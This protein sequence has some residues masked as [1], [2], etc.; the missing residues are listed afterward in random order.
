MVAL[1]LGVAAGSHEHEPESGGPQPGAGSPQD[2]QAVRAERQ[3]LEEIK[4]ELAQTRLELETTLKAQHKHLKELD[5][6][7]YT[8]IDT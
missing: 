6:L 4:S 1:S 7:R 3:L 5:T 8:W 2:Q